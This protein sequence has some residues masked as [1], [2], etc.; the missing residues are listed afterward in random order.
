MGAFFIYLFWCLKCMGWSSLGNEHWYSNKELFEQILAMKNDMQKLSAELQRTTET[1]KKYNGLREEIGELRKE[2]VEIQKRE[3]ERQAKEL[4]R[5][6]VGKAVR[7]WGGWLI[8]LIMFVL[9]IIKI[10][11][12]G[13]KMIAIN[14]VIVIAVIVGLVELARLSE[15]LKPK[16]LPLLSLG[17]GIA[18]GLIY[19]EGP[20]QDK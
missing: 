17:L 10:A 11:H 4:E 16:Y 19:F 5:H 8:A 14:D 1:I 6:S 7:D 20:I 18:A 3:A 13:E 12:G 9:N 15:W 2:I